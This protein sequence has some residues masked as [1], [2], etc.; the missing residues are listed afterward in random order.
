MEQVEQPVLASARVVA[1]AGRDGGDGLADR[2]HLRNKAGK[3]F[4]RC[5]NI[6]PHLHRLHELDLRAGVRAGRT[7]QQG[8][9]K[10]IRWE[11]E[12]PKLLFQSAPKQLSDA[13]TPVA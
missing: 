3:I 9:V 11:I 4:A 7:L 2:D 12:Y 5:K 8:E 6:F 13:H 10:V 1:R